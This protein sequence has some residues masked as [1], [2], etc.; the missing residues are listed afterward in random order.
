LLVGVGAVAAQ[1]VQIT[2]AAAVL[3]DIGHQL[4]HLGEIHLLKQI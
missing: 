1:L 4:E 2:A 3:A